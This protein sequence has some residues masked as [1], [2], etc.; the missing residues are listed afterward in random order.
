MPVQSPVVLRV[1]TPAVLER[2]APVKSVK[3]SEL[4]PKVELYKFVLVARPRVLEAETMRE[5]EA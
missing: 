1:K 5:L 4:R 3:Y 2:P